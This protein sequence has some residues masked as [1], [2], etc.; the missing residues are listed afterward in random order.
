M[1]RL[2]I[3]PEIARPDAIGQAPAFLE[4]LEHASRAAAA[5]RPVLVVGERGT[6]KEL[7]AARVHFLSQRW[8]GPYVT[9]NCAALS[10][11]LL[12]SELFGHEQGAFTG[13]VARREGR[14]ERADAGTLFLDEIATAADAV[15][16]KLLRAVEYGEFE[17]LGGTKTVRADVRVVAATN[18]DLPAKVAAGDFRADLLDRLAF[19]VVT[20]PPLRA[21]WEDIPIL[22]EH[23]GRRMAA[24]LGQPRFPG[25]AMEAMAALMD[26]DWPGNIRELKNVV[27]RAVNRAVAAGLGPDRPIEEVQ[28]DPFTS[29]YRP[30][31]PSAEAPPSPAKPQLQDAA[32]PPSEP[33]SL[34]EEVDALEV[35]RV[36]QALRE[37][38]WRQNDAAQRLGLTYH[39]LRGLIRKHAIATRPNTAPTPRN[40]EATSEENEPPV[41]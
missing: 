10:G 38:G 22:A 21:R 31:A 11:D 29:P 18:E 7:I 15:Q 28:L 14:F 20:L 17:R 32:M 41:R 4:A 25:F 9:L 24:S 6:G 40:R 2:A 5:A 12:D 3:M 23:F 39:P 37:A 1:V 13:A 34:T 27:E 19:E 35:R 26:H 16:E 36:S 8:D 33:A 30:K